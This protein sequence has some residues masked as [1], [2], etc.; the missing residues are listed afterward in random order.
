[1]IVDAQG[2]L[3]ARR[4]QD[5]GEGV[6]TAEVVLP[7]KPMP[8]ESIPKTFWIPREMPDDWKDAW[9]RWFDLG[10]DYYDMVTTRY[11]ETGVVNEYTPKYLR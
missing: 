6:V 3:L 2:K 4:A 9:E 1:M 7:S 10:A 5:A 8:S 11:L